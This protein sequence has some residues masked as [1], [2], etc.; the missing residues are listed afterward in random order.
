MDIGYIEENIDKVK[1]KQ[2]ASIIELLVDAVNDYP[3]FELK[4]TEE[5]FK[6]V[7]RLL[8]IQE[9]K[10]EHLD[11]YLKTKRGLQDAWIQTSLSSLAEAFELM[12]L[13]KIEFKNVLNK[14]ESLKN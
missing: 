9:I 2:Y 3:I 11:S 5:Y 1:D 7:K 4:D 14:I 12:G 13:Y 6:E 8:N 10:L